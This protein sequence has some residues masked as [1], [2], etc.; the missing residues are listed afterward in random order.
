[1]DIKTDFEDR[2]L[3]TGYG[4]LHYVHHAGSGP[5][6]ILIHGLAG[7][8]RTWTRMVEY[9]SDKLNIYA[10]D[11]LGHGES[12]APDINYSLKMHYDT[13]KHLVQVENLRDIYIFGHSYG[14]WIAAYYALHE[15]VEGIILEDPAGLNELSEDKYIENPDDRKAMVKKAL[16]LNPRVN[17][18]RSMLDA[19]N[20]EAVLTPTKLGDIK[21]R[22]LLIWGKQDPMVKVKYSQTFK[23]SIPHSRLV[24]L[25]NDKHTPHYT[26]PEKIARMLME[27][28]EK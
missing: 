15:Y 13:L 18:I 10:L 16:A 3:D 4:K 20:S 2:Y 12:D 27:F 22:T 1:M 25:E 5:L 24:I 6:V 7:S 26:S 9:L 11:L 14:G 17:V 28:V 8:T 21:C 23:E 19:D